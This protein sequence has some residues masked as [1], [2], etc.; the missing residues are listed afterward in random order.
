MVG[1]GYPYHRIDPEWARKH[2]FTLW[3]AGVPRNTR[4]GLAKG[5]FLRKPK[6]KPAAKPKP[7]PNPIYLPALP[8]CRLGNLANPKNQSEILKICSSKKGRSAEQPKPAE[9]PAEKPI[10]KSVDK[11]VEKPESSKNAGKSNAESKNQGDTKTENSKGDSEKKP[12]FTFSEEEDQKLLELKAN[13]GTWKS[14][15]QEMKKPQGA[16]KKR[17]NEI[18]PAEAKDN[19]KSK[20]NDKAKGNDQNKPSKKKDDNHKC[21]CGC[22]NADQQ[23]AAAQADPLPMN[24]GAL[25]LDVQDEDG[26]WDT[27]G[28]EDELQHGDGYVVI[29]PDEVFNEDACEALGQAIY[30]DYNNYHMRLASRVFDKTGIRV[31]AQAVKIKLERPAI[32]LV[33]SRDN[34]DN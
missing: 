21:E 28:V 32:R 34:T 2:Q 18:A 9:K 33:A 11:P 22:H 23:P 15:A 6:S 27:D 31:S 1:N 25:P 19:D 17:Y 14:M 3:L 12:S 30:A 7:K 29:Y 5:K 26:E 24:D 13:G 10:H 8:A 16:L 4:K 20:D